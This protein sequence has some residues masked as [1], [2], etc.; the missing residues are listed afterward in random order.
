MLDKIDGFCAL[1]GLSPA[2][3]MIAG[4]IAYQGG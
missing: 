1:P 2:A 4:R 3:T